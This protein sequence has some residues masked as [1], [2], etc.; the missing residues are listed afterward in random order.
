M[1]I[2]KKQRKRQWSLSLQ[3]MGPFFPEQQEITDST[4]P[5]EINKFS[6]LQKIH[7]EF[8]EIESCIERN[9]W[10]IFLSE[11]E[12]EKIPESIGTFKQ[13]SAIYKIVID[14]R[15][16]ASKDAYLATPTQEQEVYIFAKLNKLLMCLKGVFIKHLHINH[17]YSTY[18]N[19]ERK[20]V[21][22]NILKVE[23][24]FL[25]VEQDETNMCSNIVFAIDFQAE[26]CSGTRTT[27]TMSFGIDFYLMPVIWRENF[28]SAVKLMISDG[29][30]EKRYIHLDMLSKWV[31]ENASSTPCISLESAEG[32]VHENQIRVLGIPKKNVRVDIAE[33]LVSAI[34]ESS[35]SLD[36]SQIGTIGI[37]IVIPSLI[38]FRSNIELFGRFRF[39]SYISY[40]ADQSYHVMVHTRIKTGQCIKEELV[41][42][43]LIGLRLRQELFSCSQ[44][45]LMIS[46]VGIASPGNK[47]IRDMIETQLSELC[48]QSSNEYPS[49][50]TEAPKLFDEI[51]AY[52]ANSLK[53]AENDEN[54]L[55]RMDPDIISRFR[56]LL[57]SADSFCFLDMPHQTVTMF[58]D[59]DPNK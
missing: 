56:I 21:M 10:K 22:H 23:N 43:A 49:V 4:F 11:L 50:P 16:N 37:K 28:V 27:F 19:R 40:S 8:P 51:H 26:S 41:V 14:C 39:F 15:P 5:G 45:P 32:N 38:E 6:R 3:C 44:K 47:S 2:E 20:P 35:I 18:T 46:L 48:N 57:D 52:L 58:L 36:H 55:V 25:Q 59:F 24:L 9:T 33:E 54:I 30:E 34:L 42:A 1:K 12:M 53:Y 13:R 29:S 7:M 31:D 17:I